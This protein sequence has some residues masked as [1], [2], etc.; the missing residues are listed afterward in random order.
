[1][2]VSINI[3]SGA[4]Y[5]NN[6]FK[7]VLNRLKALHTFIPFIIVSRVRPQIL[8]YIFQ[9]YFGCVNVKRNRLHAGDATVQTVKRL[10]GAA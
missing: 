3:E 10:A 1:M 9:E 8:F 7:H 5:P 6:I 4:L 2:I